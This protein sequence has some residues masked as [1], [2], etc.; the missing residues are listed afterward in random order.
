M[1]GAWGWASRPSPRS[2][3]PGVWEEGALEDVSPASA[4][5]RPGR[6]QGHEV[7]PPGELGPRRSAG[8]PGGSL[9][10]LRVS[11]WEEASPVT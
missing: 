4:A 11:S 2:W 3:D 9:R 7:P 6:V 1:A 10:G 5:S 8:A